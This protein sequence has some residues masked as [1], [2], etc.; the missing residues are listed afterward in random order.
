MASLTHPEAAQAH[1]P[2]ILTLDV[3]TSSVRALLFDATGAAVQ[4]TQAQHSYKLITSK[5]GEVSV[6]ADMLVEVVAKT[7]DETLSAAGPLA[8]QLG[9]VATAAF[10]HSLVGVDASNRPLMPLL[11]W[12]DTRPRRA[13][14]EL[15][16]QLNE[17]AIHERNGTP[18]HASFWPAK[19]RWLAAEQPDVFKHAAQWLSFG[20]YLHR[21]LLGRSVCSLSMASGTGLLLVR[22]R[23]W[24]TDLLN[25]LGV[26]AEQLPPLGDLRD[27][28]RGLV[29]AFAA[30]WPTLR[31]VP[32]F[33]AIGDGAAANVGSGCVSSDRWALTI[34]TSSA[35][36]VIISPE[37][38]IP[39][40]GLWLYL[41][42]AQRAVLGGALS[43]GGNLFAWLS[44]TLRLPSLSE[45]ESLLASLPP[46]GHGLTILPFPSGERSLGWH[47]EARMTIDDISIHTSP[48]DIL[49]ACI[50]ALAYQIG[51]VYTRL[52][53][54]LHIGDTKPRVIGSGGALLSSPI[55][56]QVLAGV[57]NTPLFPSREREASA[58]GVALLALEALEAFPGIAR[59]EPDL[60]APVLPDQRHAAIYQRA[61]ARQQE[62]Y[63]KVLPWGWRQ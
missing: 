58:R 6:D 57:L 24:D 18:L 40:Y 52:T 15:R 16:A 9:A 12:E 11:T 49:R 3:G 27:Y 46:D 13:S 44:N 37:Q 53:A 8:A 63:R 23:T 45:A 33:P 48:A 61:A 35:M 47:D 2:F 38:T 22:D 43:E 28:L 60:E 19:L 17:K 7:I 55:L 5:E 31:D 32:W 34:G 4:G 29:P 36:R 59:V 39:P 54:T 50:E 1:P 62:L 30:R 26:R 10:W 20:E 56:Q 21:R 41:L 25:I 14:A 42:D 51:A